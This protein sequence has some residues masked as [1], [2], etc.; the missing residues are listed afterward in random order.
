MAALPVFE[1]AVTTRPR[2]LGAAR[3]AGT[4]PRP[5]AG[6]ILA[7]LAAVAVV[8][9]PVNVATQEDRLSLSFLPCR[10]HSFIHSIS[11][12]FIDSFISIHSGL[13]RRLASLLQGSDPQGQLCRQV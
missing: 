6:T 4:G 1:G 11:P 8:T 9:R 5:A 3:P 2:I 13:P 12:V 10:C 7:A